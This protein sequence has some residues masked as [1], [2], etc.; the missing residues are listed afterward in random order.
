VKL[1]RRP[2]K[3]LEA[4]ERIKGDRL[5]EVKAK[6]AAGLSSLDHREGVDGESVFAELEKPLL[7]RGKS[8]RR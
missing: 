5:R 8:T 7:S 6:I 4:S 1:S 3:L 2:S